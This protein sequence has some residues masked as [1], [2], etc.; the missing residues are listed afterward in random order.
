MPK[1][2]TINAKCQ[3][4]GKSL[5]N[6]EMMLK[7]KPSIKLNLETSNN[8]GTIRL[9]SIYGCYEHESDI[10]LSEGEI[11]RFYCPHCNKEL[12]SNDECDSPD[13]NAPM[14]QMVLE[15]GGHIYFCS[16]KGCK[17]HYV[18]FEDLDTE[19]RKFY[20]EYGF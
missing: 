8:R 10:Y 14:V 12:R 5:M 13:C 6:Q 18:A 20:H 16:R 7:G 2:I 17:K 1:T 11:A 3:H 4:C 19:V 15:V 9:C